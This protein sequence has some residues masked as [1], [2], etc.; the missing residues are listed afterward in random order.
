MRARLSVVV[1][2]L[3]TSARFG[4]CSVD[5]I[6]VDSCPGICRRGSL[7]ER[8]VA[9]A[10]LSLTLHGCVHLFIPV[11]PFPLVALVAQAAWLNGR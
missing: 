7:G 4:S 1:C 9:T 5:G 11:D 3:A 8:P 10:Y 2:N 6:L